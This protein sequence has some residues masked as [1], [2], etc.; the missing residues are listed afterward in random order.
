MI[1][2][3]PQPEPADFD[4]KVRK[5][6]LKYLRDHNLSLGQPL[7]LKT[8][9]PPHW[10]KCM[11][12]LHDRYCGVCAYLAIFIERVTGACSVDHFI[13]KS[14]LAGQAYEWDNY[15]LA[16]SIM[17]SRKREYDD[18][19]DPFVIGQGWFRLELVSGRIYPNPNALNPVAAQDTIDRLKLDDGKCREVRARHFQDYISGDVSAAYLRRRSPFIW[20]EADRQGLLREECLGD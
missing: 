13:A 5:K 18:V 9:I 20:F 12:D 17:N 6:G 10:R 8:K 4:A 19:L 1:P 14:S 15:R 16:C 11:D 7:P 3:A 2:V